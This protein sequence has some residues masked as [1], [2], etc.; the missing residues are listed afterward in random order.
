[1]A[2]GMLPQTILRRNAL[3]LIGIGAVGTA[4]GGGS[5]AAKNDRDPGR[6]FTFN[7]LAGNQRPLVGSAGE[8]RGVS[9]GGLPWIVDN[10]QAKLHSNGHLQVRV[11]GLVIDPDD[12]EAQDRGLAGINPAPGFRAILSCI[13]IEDE[14]RSVVNLETDTVSTDQ[15]G[16]AKISEVLDLPDPCYA[17]MVFVTSPGGDWFAA[18]GSR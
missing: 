2:L 15:E 16:D 11:K 1:M 10:A 4:V 18:S 3:K 9:A 5:A 8:I 14:S 12:D 7:D 6:M 13:T 17:P